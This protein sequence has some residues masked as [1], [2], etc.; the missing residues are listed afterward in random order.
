MSLGYAEK[1]SYR[2]DLGGQLG[3]PEVF[4]TAAELEAKVEHLAQ[5]VREAHNIVAFTGAGISTACGIPDFRGPSGIWTLQRRGQP[6]PRPKVSFA[7]ARPSFTHAALVSLM[8]S[9]KLTY[10]VSQNVDGLHLRS[11]VPRARLA[12]LHG[13]CFAERCAACGTEYI[14]DFEVET[15]GFKPTGRRCDAAGCGGRLHDHVLDWE[16]ALPE[17]E[18]ETSERHAREADLAICLGTS[19]QITPACNLPLKTTR[20]YRGKPAPGKLVIINLQRTQHDKRAE[21]SGGVVIRAKVDDVMRLLMVKLGTAVGPYIREDTVVVRHEIKGDTLKLAVHSRAGPKYAHPM[22][23]S[24][25]FHVKGA[26]EAVVCAA[27]P[28]EAAVPAVGGD[29]VVARIKL[30]LA[31]V[32]AGRQDAVSMTY[33]APA[34]ARRGSKGER[35]WTF[36]SQVVHYCGEEGEEEVKAAE[37]GAAKRARRE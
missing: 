23:R 31:A 37:N 5:L 27:P 30:E 7:L 4:D 22:V 29:A 33:T 12:E 16:D 20:A 8:E 13:N 6:L 19:L 3:A 1:L 14:R 34:A 9:G 32:A 2:E 18:L 17:D 15:V 25:S 28:F 35:E 36:V 24:A 11:G 26:A 21:G 10:V